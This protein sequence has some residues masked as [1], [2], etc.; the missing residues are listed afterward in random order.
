MLIVQSNEQ[1]FTYYVLNELIVN[2]L[3][4]QQIYK[5]TNTI[6]LLNCYLVAVFSEH[7]LISWN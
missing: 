1:I 6:N 4:Y 2:D 7:D 3:S 5:T